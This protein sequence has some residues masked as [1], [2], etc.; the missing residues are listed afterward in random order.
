MPRTAPATWVV[1]AAQEASDHTGGSGRPVTRR[2]V[3]GA[4]ALGAAALATTRLLESPAAAAPAPSGSPRIVVVGAGLAGL[5]AA[6]DLRKAGY[7]ATVVEASTRLGGRCWSYN[8]GELGPGLVAEHG[9]ELI[10]Q[11]HTQTRQLAQEL[12][13]D[14]DNLLA[15]EAP[16]TESA[17]WFLGQRYSYA[18][19]TADIKEIWQTLHKDVSAASY[20]TLFDSYTQRGWELDHTSVYDY[21]EQ[22]VPG[23]HA[24][25]LGR[26][27]DV[28][29]TIEYGGDTSEQ[30]SLNLLYLLAYS[31][32]GQLRI[33]GPSNEKYHVRGGN[34]LLVRR[35][36]EKLGDSVVVGTP[37]QSIV[38]NGDG[39]YR[40]GLSGSPAV[41]ADHVVLALPFS[42][43]RQVD[44]SRAGFDA[45]KRKAIAQLPMG[46]NS[47]LH[48]RFD[49]R[50]W[51]DQG[52]NGET[53][54]D[55]GYQNT[56]EV[57]RA[58]PGSWWTTPAARSERR[59]HRRT[60]RPSSTPRGS[61]SRS[62]R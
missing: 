2:T 13:L 47:K 39:T 31:G 27:L 54:A 49:R 32:Q 17:S 33:F 1:R 25:P 19:A 62:G 44:Y 57:S 23:G 36:A 7:R 18:Q 24:S 28:A 12:G 35:L 58:R 45:I 48:V 30:S 21:I 38:R 52:C 10:D 34:D 29:Y 50:V 16:G 26:L 22:V 5:C 4:G 61:S 46:T 37:L 14:L 40:L 53:Y 20:P 60:A 55:L 3:L 41:T 56:W 43:L 42:L 59:S 51:R 15:G 11:G 9:G 8:S 6:Y